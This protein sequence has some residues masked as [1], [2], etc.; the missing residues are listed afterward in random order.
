MSHN[1]NI[2]VNALLP[3]AYGS[4]KSGNS[5]KE[6]ADKNDSSQ[7]VVSED[8]EEKVQ[9]LPCVTKV[10]RFQMNVL[11]PI[12]FMSACRIELKSLKKDGHLPDE[13]DKNCYVKQMPI[14][15]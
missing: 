14:L 7:H 4:F 8:A 12:I 5:S 15:K 9:T 3:G 6:G 1:L 13:A 2:N 11:K 10:L